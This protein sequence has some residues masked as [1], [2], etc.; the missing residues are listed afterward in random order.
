MV[1]VVIRDVVEVGKFLPSLLTFELIGLFG[2]RERHQSQSQTL[3]QH[4]WRSARLTNHPPTSQDQ[5]H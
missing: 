2:A 5:N 3:E 1:A 4:L